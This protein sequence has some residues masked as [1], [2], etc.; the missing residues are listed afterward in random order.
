MSRIEKHFF[1]LGFIT[2]LVDVFPQYLRYGKRREW[3]IA[4][5]CFVCFLI[6]LSMVTRV[7][8]ETKSYTRV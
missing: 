5:N 2:A 7:S 3:F 1:P 8:V 6:G 4:G